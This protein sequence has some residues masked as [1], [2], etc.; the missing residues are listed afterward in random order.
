[1]SNT[2]LVYDIW[3]CLLILK[4]FMYY[5]YLWSAEWWFSLCMWFSHCREHSSFFLYKQILGRY[6]DPC[7]TSML[8]NQI[9]ESQGQVGCLS[10]WIIE[11]WIQDSKIA[12]GRWGTTEGINITIQ[13]FT[14]IQICIFTLPECSYTCPNTHS[15]VTA[16]TYP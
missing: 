7:L 8:W 1:M 12:I 14:S 15:T 5:T 3:L 2:L 9:E 13:F 4:Y 11:F 16:H 10:H 6:A